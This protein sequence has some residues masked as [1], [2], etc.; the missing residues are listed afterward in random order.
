[1]YEIVII[2][3]DY[4]GWWL[5]D[6]WRED[7]TSSH[8]FN[9]YDSMKIKYDEIH[10]DLKDKYS[11]HKIGKYNIPAFFDCCEIEYCDDCDEDTQIYH[12]LVVFKDGK[13]IEVN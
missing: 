4:E 5:F 3:A 12:S 9:D 2:T 6:E 13:V 11:S 10:N 1:M 7:V 8:T